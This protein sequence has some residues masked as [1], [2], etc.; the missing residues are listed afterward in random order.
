MAVANNDSD[1]N[2][3]AEDTAVAAA[4]AM[5]TFFGFADPRSAPAPSDF[6]GVNAA[7]PMMLAGRRRRW[8]RWF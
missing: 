3:A 7:M 6:T 5:T 8:S 2:D 4:T 1:A